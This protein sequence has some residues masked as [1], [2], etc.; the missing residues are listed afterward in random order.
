MTDDSSFSSYELLAFDFFKRFSRF[1]FAVKRQGFIKKTTDAQP[2]WDKFTKKI[3]DSFAT[4][5]SLNEL[6]KDPPK[7]QIVDRTS[8][9]PVLCW[10]LPGPPHK[11]PSTLVPAV[12]C[13]KTMRNNL[14]HGGKS[15]D[16]AEW[17]DKVRNMKLLTLGIEVM[18]SL[19]EH[20][21]RNYDDTFG[22]DYSGIY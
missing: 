1:E 12:Q 9:K 20:Y 19:A 7:R 10:Q 6:I 4:P 13:L 11:N 5:N 18:D 3:E 16:G 2:C 14:F 22:N 8:G 15:V 17:D 21:S